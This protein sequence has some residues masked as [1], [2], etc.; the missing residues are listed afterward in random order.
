MF[1]SEIELWTGWDGIREENRTV[2]IM[3]AVCV[4]VVG[5]SLSPPP[6]WV[7]GRG[8]VCSLW[9]V[10]DAVLQLQGGHHQKEQKSAVLTV[11]RSD[12]ARTRGDIRV[13]VIYP[14]ST[15]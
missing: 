8:L 9:Y 6:L 14:D 15:P 10:G 5:T 13:L 3:S 11:G 1:F 2:S 4:S 12:V 7:G